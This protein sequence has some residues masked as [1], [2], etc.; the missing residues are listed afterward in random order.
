MVYFWYNKEYDCIHSQQECD[1]KKKK[2]AILKN[3]A[4]KW[5]RSVSSKSSW[6]IQT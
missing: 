2:A 3:L 1:L 5:P 6:K 4:K